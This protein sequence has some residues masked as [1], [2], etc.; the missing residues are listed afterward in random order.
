[1]MS[2]SM[3]SEFA[4]FVPQEHLERIAARFAAVRE[5]DLILLEEKYRSDMAE[6]FCNVAHQLR[7]PLNIIGLTVQALAE[8]H[9][10]GELTPTDAEATA[11]QTMA[12]V[13][14]MSLTLED[15][16]R[17]LGGSGLAGHCNVR[18]AVDMALSIFGPGLRRNAISVDCAIREEIM[19]AADPNDL[20]RVMHQLLKSARRYLMEN[21]TEEPRITI[22]GFTEKKMVVV[23]VSFNCGD[24]PAGH[25]SA[26]SFDALTPLDIKVFDVSLAG[27]ILW[28]KAGGVLKIGKSPEGT[29]FRVELPADK[30]R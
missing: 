17:F 23:T 8:N 7:Q 9:A 6:I 11:G 3:E 10:R 27:V 12:M 26:Q 5:R 30:R 14:R 16:C 4:G 13:K 18:E 24:L 21:G 2:I 1:M 28:E 25:I 22:R 20:S 15:C 19:A 29:E